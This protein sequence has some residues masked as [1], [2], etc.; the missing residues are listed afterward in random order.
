[1]HAARCGCHSWTEFPEVLRDF[2][3]AP[4]DHAVAD[5]QGQRIAAGVQNSRNLFL[6]TYGYRWFPQNRP[7]KMGAE[8][9]WPIGYVERPVTVV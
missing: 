1:M 4:D 5:T 3:F 2:V 8:D 9:I 7:Y 6:K